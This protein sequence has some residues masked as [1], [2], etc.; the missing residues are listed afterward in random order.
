[1]DTTPPPPPAFDAESDPDSGT[2][3]AEEPTVP[4]RSLD[5]RV[6]S[7]WRVQ[8]LI[9]SAFLFSVALVGGGMVSV[10][11]PAALPWVVAGCGVLL[12]IRMWLLLWYPIRAYQVWGYRIDD[13][14]LETRQGIWFRTITLLPLS[15]LQHADLHRGPLERAF[16]LASLILYTA[17]T[18]HASILLPGLDAAEA[19]HLRDQLV[20]AGGDDAV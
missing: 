18:Q 1:M 16:G 2:V 14:V 7:Y 6:V 9:S 12:V 15:R 17:G 10:G 8:S 13:K 5:P 20:A 3:P 4:M 19:A 11:K